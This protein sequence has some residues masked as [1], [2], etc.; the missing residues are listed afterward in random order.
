MAIV[1]ATEKSAGFV[2]GQL[3]S[4]G[5]DNAAELLD[6]HVARAVLVEQPEHAPPDTRLPYGTRARKSLGW[7]MR[8]GCQVRG[9]P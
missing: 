1:A 3:D 8:H 6:V 9:A 5:K 2:L 7:L 4:E